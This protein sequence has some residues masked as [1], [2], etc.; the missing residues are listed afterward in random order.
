MSPKLNQLFCKGLLL[1]MMYSKNI[2]LEIVHSWAVFVISTFSEVGT[3]SVIR[4]MWWY[5]EENRAVFRNFMREKCA[6]YSGQCP[7]S[8]FHAKVII[9]WENCIRMRGVAVTKIDAVGFNFHHLKIHFNCQ[10]RVTILLAWSAEDS[11]VGELILLYVILIFIFLY[12]QVRNHKCAGKDVGFCKQKDFTSEF[13]CALRKFSRGVL[14]IF[15]NCSDI[16]LAIWLREV[17]NP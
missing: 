5:D 2:M 13:N 7:V 4:L 1:Q 15:Y 12:F 16:S 11:V 10:L 9:K 17:W 8:T 14:L 3:A 6:S